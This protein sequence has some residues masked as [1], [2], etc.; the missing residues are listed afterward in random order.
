M[1]GDFVVIENFGYVGFIVVAIYFIILIVNNYKTNRKSN[2]SACIFIFYLLIINSI[3]FG[4]F[5]SFALPLINGIFWVVPFIISVIIEIVSYCK[6]AKNKSND[7]NKNA[8]FDRKRIDILSLIVVLIIVVQFVAVLAYNWWVHDGEDYFKYKEIVRI[9]ENGDY[10]KSVDGYYKIRTYEKANKRLKYLEDKKTKELYESGQYEKCIELYDALIAHSDYRDSNEYRIKLYHDDYYYNSFNN[11]FNNAIKNNNKKE[12]YRLK[13]RMLKKESKESWSMHDMDFSGLT[14]FD[15]I[16]YAK[17]GDVVTFGQYLIPR[18]NQQK[19]SDVEWVVQSVDKNIVKLRAKE[20]FASYTLAREEKNYVGSSL[21]KYLNTEFC[22]NLFEDYEKKLLVEIDDNDYITVPNINEVDGFFAGKKETLKAYGWGKNNVISYDETIPDKPIK[23]YTIDYG[24]IDFDIASYNSQSVGASI[25][26]IIMIDKEKIDETVSL[27]TKTIDDRI[28]DLK[29]ELNENI[30]NA[31]TVKDH[32]TNDVESYD[33]I[34]FGR[35]PILS[36]EKEIEWVV[37]E[38]SDTEATLLSKYCV[39]GHHYTEYF[40][41][42]LENGNMFYWENSDIRRFLNREFFGAFFNDIEK[43][44][45]LDSEIKNNNNVRFKTSSGNATV[46]KVYI[47]STEEIDKY[48]VSFDYEDLDKKHNI[49][50]LITKFN[51]M[52][53]VFSENY[54]YKDETAYWLRDMGEFDWTACCVDSKGNINDRGEYI[55]ESYGIRP[56]IKIRLK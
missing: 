12:A 46:D 9:E 54:E 37:L 48:I 14:N 41:F 36:D 22:D 28:Y 43:K 35:F 51:G 19:K 52:K 2:I 45:I 38:K 11:L 49:K 42:K 15:E 25:L 10:K 47:L 5:Y 27:K 17:V 8:T 33:T 13:K 53:Y 32:D 24:I 55:S 56:V 18:F 1:F 44:I 3:S 34:K 6:Y 7:S 16:K 29:K 40:D 20:I 4:G 31:K 26:P 30:K 50:K 39:L 23:L 21:Q